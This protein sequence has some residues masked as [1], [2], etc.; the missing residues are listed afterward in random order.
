MPASAIHPRFVRVS[1]VHAWKRALAEGR[2]IR[3]VARAAGRDVKCVRRYAGRSHGRLREGELRLITEDFA[4]GRSPR[5]IAADLG[6][7]HSTILRYTGPTRHRLHVRLVPV[8]HAHGATLDAIERMTRI[9]PREAVA[10]IRADHAAR[11]GG[12]S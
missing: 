9:S 1:D 6:R 4:T 11:R 2:T 7:A 3:D 8:L 5:T 10:L 12:R